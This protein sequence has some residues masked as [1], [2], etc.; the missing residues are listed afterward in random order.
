ML[1]RGRDAAGG[2]SG[3]RVSVHL[4]TADPGAVADDDD[5]LCSN[6][7]NSGLARAEGNDAPD[8][9]VRRNANGHAISRNN[10]DAEAA[11]S[12]A[13]LRE[14]F[15]TR[16]ALNPIETA[17]MNGHHGTLHVYE[18]VLAQSASNPFMFL[19]KHCAI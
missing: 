14:H 1:A 11:H 13:E 9:I 19:D 4:R 16:V 12:A 15:V 18:I 5:R 10:F 7:N 3:C 8:G 6:S 17:A 2:L